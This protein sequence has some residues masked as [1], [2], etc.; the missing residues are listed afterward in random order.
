MCDGLVVGGVD[1]I[2]LSGV[3]ISFLAEADSRVCFDFIRL[4][5]CFVNGIYDIAI[6]DEEKDDGTDVNTDVGI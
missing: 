6:E 2:S 1:I 5:N 4:L 3:I